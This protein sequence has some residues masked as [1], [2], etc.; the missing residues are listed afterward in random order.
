MESG[1][2]DGNAG[3]RLF[4]SLREP[5]NL[6]GLKRLA[7]ASLNCAAIALDAPYRQTN[8]RCRPL[9]SRTEAVICLGDKEHI[10]LIKM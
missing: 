8:S 3:S 6:F 4:Y 9:G 2:I 1:L 5:A 10:V 7:R